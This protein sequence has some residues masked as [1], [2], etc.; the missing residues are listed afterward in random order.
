[1]NPTAFAQGIETGSSKGVLVGFEFE[2]CVP[3]ETISGKPA[4]VAKPEGVGTEWYEMLPE[5]WPDM[6]GMDVIDS[7]YVELADPITFND[8]HFDD[9]EALMAEWISTKIE[10]RVKETFD[11]L[12]L[13]LKKRV[14]KYWNERRALIPTLPNN[15]YTFCG[16]ALHV[17]N[18]RQHDSF[19]TALRSY[20]VDPGIEHFWLDLFGTANFAELYH[21]PDLEWDEGEMCNHFGIGEDDYEVGGGRNGGY[22]EYDYNGASRIMKPVIQNAFGDTKVF[23]DYHERS[24]NTT[25]WYIEPDG[26]LEPNDGDGACEI[27]TPPMPVKEAVIALKEFYSIAR[28]MNLYTSKTNKTGLHINVSI[29]DHIDVLKLAV[30]AGDQYILKQWGREN[31]GYAQSVLK[32][33]RRDLPKVGATADPTDLNKKADYKKLLQ[34]ARDISEDHMASISF[35]GKYVSF[36]HAGGDYLNEQQAVIDVVGRFVRAMVIAADPAMYKD[37]YMSKLTKLVQGEQKPAVNTNSISQLMRYRT[38]P[39]KVRTSSIYSLVPTTSMPQLVSEIERKISNELLVPDEIARPI[40]KQNLE[41]AKAKTS[42]GQLSYEKIIAAQGPQ[43]LSFSLAKSD[44]DVGDF[45]ARGI[46]DSNSNENT[47]IGILVTSVVDAQ[48]K[49]PL[50]NLALRQIMVDAKAK[51]RANTL[52]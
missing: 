12:S 19:R 16:R 24:K 4:E 9:I 1:M 44:D 25:S 41:T 13:P 48:P 52:K 40:L 47:K 42:I 32:M 39:I 43:Q 30:F 28:N 23:N 50:H 26:S 34:V 38:M 27:V 10:Q 35:N 45:Y 51:M 2:V 15:A 21:R 5:N 14:I 36:R 46:Y 18:G 22:H 6:M 29:P 3:K 7:S 33:L 17:L 11:R 49:T 37:E 20:R 31:N 8:K